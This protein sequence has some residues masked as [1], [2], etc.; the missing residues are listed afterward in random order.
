MGLMEEILVYNE[1]VK[2]YEDLNLPFFKDLEKIKIDQEVEYTG[3][4][5][6]YYAYKYLGDEQYWW[7]LAY[8][9]RVLDPLNITSETI[10][11]PNKQDLITLLT[12]YRRT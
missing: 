12:K 3:E 4:M 10:L 11:I 7:I 8:V 5:L 1:D 2:L 6:D 9:N